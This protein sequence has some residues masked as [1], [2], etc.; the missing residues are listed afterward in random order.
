MDSEY[1]TIAVNNLLSLDINS[2]SESEP[3]LKKHVY[4]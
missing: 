1:S 3:A 4:L 2:K